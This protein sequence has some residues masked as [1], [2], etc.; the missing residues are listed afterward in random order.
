MSADTRAAGR[1]RATLIAATVVYFAWLLVVGGLARWSVREGLPRVIRF[2]LFVLLWVA[3]WR[4]RRWARL[5]MGVLACVGL[6]GGCAL[7]YLSGLVVLAKAAPL[8]VVA[9]ALLFDAP[10]RDY[11]ASRLPKPSRPTVG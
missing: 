4:G 11:V 1:G 3:I 5:T 7:A 10:T 2:V 9:W 6:V 8:V